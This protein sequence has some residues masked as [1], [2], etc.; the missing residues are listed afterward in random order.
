MYKLLSSKTVT[1]RMKVC[2]RGESEHSSHTKARKLEPLEAWGK[3]PGVG[4]SQDTLTAPSQVCRVLGTCSQRC[5]NATSVGLGTLHQF[6][7]NPVPF[8]CHPVP[9]PSPALVQPTMNLNLLFAS[10]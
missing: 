5:A 3:S 8:G 9:T 1:L 10:S 6:R 7:G 2:H 4:C